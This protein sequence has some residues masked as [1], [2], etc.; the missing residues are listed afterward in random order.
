MDSHEEQQ[1]SPGEGILQAPAHQARVQR[2]VL[3]HELTT[4]GEKN[5]DGFSFFENLK[6]TSLLFFVPKYGMVGLSTLGTKEVKASS[7]GAKV[8]KKL[9]FCNQISS[10]KVSKG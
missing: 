8:C 4:G 10:A 5:S 1:P 6:E 9:K 7:A 3:R 2:D